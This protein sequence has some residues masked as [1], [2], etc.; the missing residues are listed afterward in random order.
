MLELPENDYDFIR[1]LLE[2]FYQKT[3]SSVAKTL[4]TSW[5]KEAKK[6]VKVKTLGFKCTWSYYI[7][8]II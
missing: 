4:L 6:F 2:E 8:E 5:P 3:D 7:L 1:N